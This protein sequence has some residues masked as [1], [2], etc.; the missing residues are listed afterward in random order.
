MFSTRPKTLRL[1]ARVTSAAFILSML[2]LFASLIPTANAASIME[3]DVALSIASTTGGVP[4]SSSDCYTVATG[5]TVEFELNIKNLTRPEMVTLVMTEGLQ[6]QGV[7]EMLAMSQTNQVIPWE[8]NG[9][10]PIDGRVDI[11]ATGLPEDTA[12]LYVKYNCSVL[13]SGAVSDTGV[14]AQAIYVDHG[15]ATIA[16]TDASLFGLNFKIATIDSSKNKNTD[17][18]NYLGTGAYTLYYN[19][20]LTKPVRFAK[21][22]NMYQAIAEWDNRG[23]N[24]LN[25]ENSGATSITGLHAGV[26][27]LAQTIPPDNYKDYTGVIELELS[28]TLDGNMVTSNLKVLNETAFQV[29]PVQVSVRQNALSVGYAGSYSYI[30]QAQTFLV[31]NT[32]PVL[33]IL[34][35]AV[36]VAGFYIQR[37]RVRGTNT[38]R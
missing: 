35:L 16:E 27:Y 22:G 28:G 10:V 15:Y 13:D 19:A 14:H 20:D 34:L 29:E 11:N 32:L 33:G 23:Q 36:S 12:S 30:R 38:N 26:Y 7:T 25:I 3:P 31:K 6:F 8:Y 2:L 9:E 24:Y 17:A 21:V 1:F 18:P 4:D 5:D 37:N